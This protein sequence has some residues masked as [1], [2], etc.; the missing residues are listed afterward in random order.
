[1]NFLQAGHAT[2]EITREEARLVVD[3]TKADGFV[4]V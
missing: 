2:G 3:G 1:M 4:P